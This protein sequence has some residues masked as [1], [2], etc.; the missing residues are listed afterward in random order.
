MVYFGRAFATFV[1]VAV[2]IID[3]NTTLT[4]GG[5]CITKT[6]VA[7]GQDF[8]A[9]IISQCDGQVDGWSTVLAVIASVSSLTMEASCGLTNV[10][11][12]IM[13]VAMVGGIARP[14]I[15]ICT[16]GGALAELKCSSMV[17]MLVSSGGTLVPTLET[18]GASCVQEATVRQARLTAMVSSWRMYSTL[19]K[20]VTARISMAVV[21]I[22][23][24][25]DIQ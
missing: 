8:V 4:G 7:D 24:V 13:M 3:V 20:V 19:V 25:G 9:V 21:P 12:S 18:G 23:L 17:A 5:S 15:D 14:A 6:Q 11:L 16:V 1:K 10:T 22:W 2:C